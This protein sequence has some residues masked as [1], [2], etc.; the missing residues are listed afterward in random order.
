MRWLMQIAFIL[1][2]FVAVSEASAGCDICALQ[3]I[4]TQ[5]YR[6]S[7]GHFCGQLYNGQSC[8]CP[9]NAQ[10]VGVPGDCR[11]HAVQLRSPSVSSESGSSIIGSIFSVLFFLLC[12]CLCCKCCK[13]REAEYVPM[14]TQ[15]NYVAVPQQPQYAPQ[16]VPQAQY[17]GQ[18]NV[19]YASAPPAPV[20]YS[21]YQGGN[22]TGGE[23]ALGAAAGV[24]TGVAVSEAMHHSNYGGNYQS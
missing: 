2:S 22:Y 7:P 1:T 13:T 23:V 4:C 12:F 14:T 24:A 16:Y 15:Q 8:C 6:G 3:G 21:S 18:P 20:V 9:D 10:C 19:V 17:V 5:A 11:C